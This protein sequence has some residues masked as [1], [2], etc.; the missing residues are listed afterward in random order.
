MSFL[1]EQYLRKVSYK[2]RNYKE[3]GNHQYNFSCPICNDSAKKK[4]KARGYAFNKNGSLI[5][6]C[7]NCG[8]GA[9]FPNFLKT[10]DPLLY[11]EFVM[12]RFKEKLSN[13]VNSEIYED[14]APYMSKNL[15]T[16]KYIPNIF[17]SLPRLNELPL[18]HPARK[19]ADSRLLPITKF[20][21]YYAEKFIEWTKGHTG[22]FKSVNN[23]NHPRVVIPF[24]AR[25]GHI[26]GYTARALNGEE[27]KYYRIFIDDNEKEKF[28]G[29]DRLDE[30]KQVY[31]LEGEIDSLFLPNAI[32][33]SNGKLQTY[34]NKNAIYIPDADRRNKHITK[35]IDEM[36]DIGL[37]VCLLPDDLPGKDINELI[38]NGMTTDKIINIINQNVYQGLT[39]KLKF[40]QWKVV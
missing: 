37:K 22:K 18:S 19:Y 28:F 4:N 9:S 10:V 7:H 23:D 32:A 33:V 27:P 13:Q 38:V 25:D 15:E 17:S 3:K 40:N 35:N 11:Q 26:I 1:E 16:K 8:Y 39:G 36:I 34:M 6:H 29:I 5:I 12:E 24:Y 21:F 31:V 2:F 14:G 20:E 30:S